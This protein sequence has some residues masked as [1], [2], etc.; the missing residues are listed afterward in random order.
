MEE[1]ERSG[2]DSR[3]GGARLKKL[4]MLVAIMAMGLLIAAPAIAQVGQEGEQ[5]GES[6]EVDQSFTVTGSGS[7]GNSCAPLQGSAQSGNSQNQGNVVQERSAS[8]DFEFDEVGS[9]IASS[10]SNSTECIQEVN[11]AASAA[12]APKA[13]PPPPPKAAPAP[14]PPPP[15]APKAAPAPPPPPPAP[16]KEEVKAEKAEVKAQKAEAKAQKA[17]A[18]A[19]KAEAKKAKE[20]PKTGG[21]GA[22]PLFALGAGTLLVAGGLLARRLTR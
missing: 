15:P 2:I 1:W 12:A 19:Q 7:N 11:Q 13:T 14:P 16:T 22:V 17:E 9:D 21:S 4:T 20:L 10:G 8:D 3:E 18:K 6:G 5:E